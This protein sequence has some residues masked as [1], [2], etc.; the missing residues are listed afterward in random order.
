M[1]TND[2]PFA[3]CTDLG[4]FL[5]FS[6]AAELFHK[7]KNENRMLEAVDRFEKTDD[8]VGF[9]TKYK[10]IE[11]AAGILEQDGIFSAF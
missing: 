9:L 3:I 11:Q 8:K 6:S 7:Y 10:Y 1:F 2:Q 4:C 5:S